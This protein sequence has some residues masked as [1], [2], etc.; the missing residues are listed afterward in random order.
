MAGTT[1]G[2]EIAEKDLEL[3][4]PGE[5]FGSEQSGMPGFRFANIMRDQDV[6]SMARAD[7]FEIVSSD[8]ELAEEHNAFVKKVYTSVYSAR[9]KLVLY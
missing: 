7:A 6:L 9:E 8:P 3:R 4:G 2:F 1:D 5:V